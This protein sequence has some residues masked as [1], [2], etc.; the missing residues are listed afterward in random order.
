MFGDAMD[1]IL[2]GIIIVAITV[3][4]ELFNID[5]WFPTFFCSRTPK[6]EKENSRTP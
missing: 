6:Q 5:Q 4:T 1:T 3:C 2:L